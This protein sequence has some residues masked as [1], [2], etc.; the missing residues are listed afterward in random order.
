MAECLRRVV[1]SNAGCD[2]NHNFH[3]TDVEIR[4]LYFVRGYHQESRKVM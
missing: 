2:P 4:F 1:V 3:N